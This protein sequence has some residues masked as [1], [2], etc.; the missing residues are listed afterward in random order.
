MP[1]SDPLD[2]RLAAWAQAYG[3]ASHALLKEGLPAPPALEGDVALIERVVQG[4]EQ[5]GRWKEARVLRCEY[6]LA[7]QEECLRLA[8]LRRIG[9]PMS[10]ASYYVYLDAARAF[11][12][13]ALLSLD[14]GPIALSA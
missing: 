3:Q 13:G 7:D 2:V 10:R 6:V 12:A 14:E 11:V 8:R 4:M 5:A 1:P 9:L